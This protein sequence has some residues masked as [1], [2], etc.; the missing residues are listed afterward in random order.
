MSHTEV[1]DIRSVAGPRQLARGRRRGG[2]ESRLELSFSW[3][4]LIYYLGRK[5]IAL[6]AG[7]DKRVFLFAAGI[8]F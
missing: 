1:W 5:T 2:G 6:T 4:Q 8:N 3:L 7:T